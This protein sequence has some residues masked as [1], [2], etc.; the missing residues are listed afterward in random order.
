MLSR[1]LSIMLISALSMVA[2][3]LPGTE[4]YRQ[5]LAMTDTSD[6]HEMFELAQWC[7]DNNMIVRYRQHLNQVIELD[8][9]HYP[10]R[11]ALGFVFYNNQWTHRSRVPRH[12][13]EQEDKARQQ[14]ADGTSDW[15]AAA[16]GPAPA[17]DEITWDLTIG[18]DPS[19][20]E[21]GWINQ[22]IGIMSRSG[23]M[24][25]QLEGAYRTLLMERYFPGSIH[26][27]KQALKGGSFRGVYGVAM[28][29]SEIWRER[30]PER[31]QAMRTLVP[32]LVKASETMR[33]EVNLEAFSM[34]MGM[35]NERRAVPR[36]IQILR[37]GGEDAQYAA[38]MALSSIT[39]LPERGLTADS[40][41]QWWSR[42][43]N[44]P[45]QVI[46]GTL[47]NDR[48]LDVSISAA[49]RMIPDGFR[50]VIPAMLRVL[51]NGDNR[52]MLMADSIL[53]RLTDSS[54]VNV[55][56]DQEER[57]RR[58]NFAKR[59]WED[60]K[61][62]FEP[63]ELRRRREQLLRADPR[64]EG[65]PERQIVERIA[66]LNNTDETR[67]SAAETFLINQAEAAIAP[68][69]RHGLTHSS[70]IVRQ[71]SDALLRQITSQNFNFQGLVGSEDDREAARQRWREW[72]R[73][74][75]HMD[76]ARPADEAHEDEAVDDDRA[77]PAGRRRREPLPF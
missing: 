73:Q 53:Q 41:Q 55:N 4:T 10:A 48:D 49:E 44:A 14:T 8:P 32:F 64:D 62:D 70:G 68:L 66:S 35:V 45:D 34:I 37:S 40:A 19:P 61:D 30:D 15:T 60:N 25:R 72:A 2:L 56:M 26:H 12:V 1:C 50:Q 28:M 3:T 11:E 24:S 54:W 17:A 39:L 42:Y 67:V 7:K 23:P 77:P 18:D 74:E 47:L 38:R 69:I 58:V 33:D 29:F 16:A 52:Q 71:R 22:Q 21:E 76:A 59:W 5:R 57:E 51:E 6:P 63:A 9:D 27:L 20:G 13:L 31:M 75:G 36:L 43:H 65:G 46:Y